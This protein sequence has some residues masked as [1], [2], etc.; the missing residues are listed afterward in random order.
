MNSPRYSGMFSYLFTLL[1]F[2]MSMSFWRMARWGRAESSG[3][4]WYWIG[5]CLT[6]L[7]CLA[8]GVFIYLRLKKSQNGV[9]RGFLFISSMI[10]IL[11]I[12]WTTFQVIAG[13]SGM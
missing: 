11:I 13:I 9:E 12:L 3:I 7:L 10:C 8:A 2:M 6:Y 5:V 4:V 1:G